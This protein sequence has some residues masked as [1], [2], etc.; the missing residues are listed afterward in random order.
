MKRPP[1]GISLC[2]IVKNEAANLTRCLSS[3]HSVVDEIIIVDT[4]STDHTISIA[5]RFG[6]TVIE[7]PWEG[8]FAQ[9]RN[10]GLTRARFPWI[11][12]MDA[13]EELDAGDAEELLL[14]ARHMEYEGFFLQVHN[15]ISE[16]IHSATA[17]VNPL[18][19]MFRRRPEHRFQ[20]RI[21][22]QIA[23]SITKH[24]PMAMLHIS[25]VKIHHYGYSGSM[26]VSRDKIR[27]NVELLRLALEQEPDD[28]FH[29]YN[30]AV[31]CM[32]M[33]DYESALIHLSQAKQHADPEISY[34]HLLFKYE[35]RCLLSLGK[36]DEAVQVCRNG[37]KSFPDYTDLWHLMGVIHLSAGQH[38]HA[39]KSFIEAV[40]QGPAP[41]HYHTE[42]GAGT[43][44]SAFGLG[45]LQEEIGDDV[46]AIHWYTK[47]LQL[48]PGMRQALNN[49]IRIM[50]S[51][52]Q[53]SLIAS[54]LQ[55][56]IKLRTSAEAKK[57]AGI[58]AEHRCYDAAVCVL[59]QASA[60]DHS[61]ENEAL[62]AMCKQLAKSR[63]SRNSPIS[64][65]LQKPAPA[66]VSPHPPLLIQPHHDDLS[67][68]TEER[69]IERTY[70]NGLTGQALND[71]QHLISPL[72]SS[73]GV[74]LPGKAR[75]AAR[76]LTAFA[77]THLLQAS[78]R[79]PDY[80]VLRKAVRI[81]PWFEHLE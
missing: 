14:C 36:S 10:A 56:T 33:N 23:A 39:E 62:L 69:R 28:P 31:E 74:A 15:H 65:A 73:S 24:R 59:E 2:M 25:N 30:M 4:G 26:V 58:L 45:Q 11:L 20:G 9:A 81:L 80:A 61:R 66:T 3:V 18:L 63:N 49:L 75:T 13:D 51:N 32:R 40:T 22:E 19:R 52:R 60:M 77:E 71:I 35:A 54:R 37:L 12:F 41:M 5:R 44:L 38:L 46:Q 64:N 6:A 48:E 7:I 70:Y 8:D 29:H 50:K 1:S 17:T 27:R 57:L 53:Q 55:E 34:F 47:A 67:A 21:H 42:T 43:Y 72:S 76:L 68:L 79:H 16:N 78:A